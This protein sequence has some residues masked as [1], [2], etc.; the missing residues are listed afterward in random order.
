MRLVVRGWRNGSQ[1][2]VCHLQNVMAVIYVRKTRF[3]LCLNGLFYCDNEK[4]YPY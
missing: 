2:G 3:G 4:D 1:K